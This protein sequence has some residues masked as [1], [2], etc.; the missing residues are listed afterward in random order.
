MNVILD[1]MKAYSKAIAN[2]RT[3]VTAKTDLKE[4]N[5]ADIAAK[6]GFDFIET[7][8]EVEGKKVPALTT[9]EDAY[10][11][12]VLPYGV[13]TEK[14]QSIPIEYSPESTGM[15]VD[16]VSVYWVNKV[17]A[18][19]KPEFPEA[20]PMV[21]DAWKKQEAGKLAMADANALAEKVRT[22]K[23]S[24]AEVAKSETTPLECAESQKFS[25]YDFPR[26]FRNPRLNP[27]EIREE[28]VPYGEAERKNKV[29]VMPG[30]SFYETVYGLNVDEVGVVFNQPEDRVFVIQLIEKDTDDVML[31]QFETAQNDPFARQ[32][33]AETV[34]RTNLKFHE[35]WIKELR[36]NAGFEWIV[37]PHDETRR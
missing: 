18:S 8:E 27:G 26:G 32:A 12:E 13:L 36:K 20:K 22:A 34:Q 25:W 3:G 6:K 28:G 29:I 30:E 1:E 9:I 4:I 14:Y 33:I 5:L 35:D 10:L 16:S 23:K 37:I 21:I 11:N 15:I 7:T 17:K 31:K 2:I 19:Y 24:L